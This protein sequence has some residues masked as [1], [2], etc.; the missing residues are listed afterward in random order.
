MNDVCGEC[1]AT[2]C[3]LAACQVPLYGHI[4]KLVADRDHWRKRAEE[5]ENALRSVDAWTSHAGVM[6]PETQRRDAELWDAMI[7]NLAEWRS[8]VGGEGT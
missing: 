7:A 2:N 4:E 6:D 8:T 1:G 3:H 5:A